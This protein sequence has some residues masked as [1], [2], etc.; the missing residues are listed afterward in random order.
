MNLHASCVALEGR[1]LLIL[2]PSGAGKSSLALQLMAFGAQLVADD[3]VELRRRGDLLIAICPA[4]LSGLIEA[5]GVGLLRAEPLAEA[6]LHLAVDLGQAETERLPERHGIVFLGCRIDL[7]R[8]TAS[9]HFPAALLQ[10]V[11]QGRGA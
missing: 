2:G 10:Y 4:S 9:A 7:V 1:G 8:A 6:V 11:R 5:R 3:R